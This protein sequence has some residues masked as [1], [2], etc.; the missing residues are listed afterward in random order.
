M[1]ATNFD[2]NP[3]RAEHEYDRENELK[4]FD[5]KG[6]V[7]SGVS[8]LPRIFID[9]QPRSPDRSGPTETSFSILIV[10]LEGVVNHGIGD[11]VL[12]R[13]IDGV[14]R[15]QEQESEVKKELYSRDESK[16]VT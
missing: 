1:A 8:K 14:K 3:D 13:I 5:V 4:A 7:N 11:G 16:K 9:R 10:D 15:F 12:S 2:E 6:L